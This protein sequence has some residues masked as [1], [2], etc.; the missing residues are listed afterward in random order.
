MKLEIIRNKK[1]HGWPKI[2]VGYCIVFNISISPHLLHTQYSISQY[3]HSIQYLNTYTVFNISIHTQ[4]S[5]S[6]YIHSIQYLN[7]YTVFNISIHTQYSI[8]H[9]IQYLNTYT[10]FNI[11]QYSISQYIHSIQYLTVFNISIHTISQY[12]H[13]IQYLNTYTVFNISIHTQYSIS[14]YIC[15][16]QIHTLRPTYILYTRYIFQYTQYSIL[17]PLYIHS[18]PQSPHT[19]VVPQYLFN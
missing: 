1:K 14:Q 8:S 18:L 4:Y 19:L 7:I 10:V 9:S 11:L 13:S 16:A 6:Q 15:W 5:I 3:I 12:I 2:Y 17:R